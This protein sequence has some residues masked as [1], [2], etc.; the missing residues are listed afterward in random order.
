MPILLRP[1]MPT[2]FKMLRERAEH[3]KA[4][5]IR[6]LLLAER[7][8]GSVSGK[9]KPKQ[10]ERMHLQFENA[11]AIDNASAVKIAAGAGKLFQLRQFFRIGSGRLFDV[12]PEGVE[13]LA[14][15]RVIW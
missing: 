9:L 10:I 12:D 3:S 15:G 4:I 7:V 5:E 13:K 1:T 11:I 8:K 2:R 6:A 14:R